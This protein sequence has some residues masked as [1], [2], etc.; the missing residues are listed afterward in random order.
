MRN[1]VSIS[2]V[3]DAVR[4]VDAMHGGMQASYELSIVETQAVSERGLLKRISVPAS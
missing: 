1:H 2:D 3:C 4:S